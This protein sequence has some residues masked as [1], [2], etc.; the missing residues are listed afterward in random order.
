MRCA[1]H[2]IFS[3]FQGGVRAHG[4]PLR[5]SPS[6][7][8]GPGIHLCRK[9]VFTGGLAMRWRQ[10]SPPG[11]SG[12]P[13]CTTAGPQNLISFTALAGGFKSVGFESGQLRPGSTNILQISSRN[14]D[15]VRSRCASKA[16][17]FFFF[18]GFY[19]R[20]WPEG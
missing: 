1:A 13:V 4:V 7:R 6:S 2:T 5:L 12:A 16:H 3:R 18:T 17:L 14:F 20:R 19:L 11:Q 10:E 8:E 9:Q 15:A